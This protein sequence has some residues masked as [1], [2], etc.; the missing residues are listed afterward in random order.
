MSRPRGP[1]PAGGEATRPKVRC[2]KGALRPRRPRD[3]RPWGRTPQG[4]PNTTVALTGQY[5]PAQ[6]PAESVDLTRDNDAG[7]EQILPAFGLVDEDM[8][9]HG[10]RAQAG[11]GSPPRCATRPL[12]CSTWYRPWPPVTRAPRR[13]SLRRWN[14]TV[15]RVVVPQ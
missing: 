3:R 10:R 11:V 5:E 14:W 7:H 1:C 8:V 2:G 4:A 9:V 15:T 6:R 12:V 13:W